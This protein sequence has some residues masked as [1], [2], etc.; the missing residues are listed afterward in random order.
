MGG[1][2]ADVL[3]ELRHRY[4]GARD[5]G[6]AFELLVQRYLRTDPMYTEQFS[7]VWLWT[8]WPDRPPVADTGID[9]VAEVAGGGLCAV[10]CKCFDE[11]HQ[12]QKSD[13]DSFFTESGKRPFT[14]RLIV[15]TTDRW[16]VH[17]EEALDGQQVPVARIGLA[18]LAASAVDWS[19]FSLDQPDRMQVHAKKHPLPHQEAAVADVMAGFE[20]HDRGRLVMA[21]G[22]GK[23][24][25]ALEIAER[26]A[27]ERVAAGATGPA[28]VL[29][30]VPS[31][32]LLNQTLRE[33]TNEASLPM[34]CYAVCS[35]TNVGKRSGRAPSEDLRVHD[36][37]FPATTD[38]A[39]LAGQVIRG[40]A[41]VEL[42]VIFSTYQSIGAVS[43]AQAAGVP[44]LDLAICDEAHRTTG[45]TLAG[46]DE[47]AFVRVHDQQ[48]LR[49]RRRLYMTATP[50]LFSATT[51]A[52]AADADAVLCSM[53][54]EALYGPEFHRLG[55]GRAV[56]AGL[57]SD[58]KVLVLNVDEDHVAR[59]LQA[60]LAD[61]HNELALDDAAKIV[62]CWNGLAKRGNLV[63]VGDGYGA[64]PQP[65]RRAVA[66]SRS[67]KDSKLFTS[68]FA[69]I[70]GTYTAE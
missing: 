7:R 18:D 9:L 53:D 3:A 36:L 54:D 64:D 43:A 4:P 30:L 1:T 49:A 32:S 66:F 20:A 26:V 41:G 40:G 48:F 24:F 34:R 46:D 50:R 8:E 61:E 23:T 16:S 56:E 11:D 69:G 10:Q 67:I 17:A 47:S 15:S 27:A 39:T 59:S 19:A 35:D 62:G 31:I 51:K 22:T 5:R 38:G 68:R 25:T 14:Q 45:V 28:H 44:E 70:I 13:I 58:Y 6:T 12:L 33:W 42:V 21:C 29:F 37:A 52:Q 60:P 65:M 63:L 55:F 57:L 2:I